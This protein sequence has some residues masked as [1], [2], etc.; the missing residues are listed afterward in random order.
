M[1]PPPGVVSTGVPTSLASGMPHRLLQFKEISTTSNHV[2]GAGARE[3]GIR[4]ET[5][6]R[7]RGSGGPT[8]LL[9]AQ[10][11]VARLRSLLTDLRI[12]VAVGDERE[13]LTRLLS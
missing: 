4:S 7:A 5:S 13:I 11:P 1:K 10:E 6:F 3:A 12:F 9:A 8:V 2:V